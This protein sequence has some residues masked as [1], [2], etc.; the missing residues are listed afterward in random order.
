M[1]TRA[2]QRTITYVK[3]GVNTPRGWL[4]VLLSGTA[5]CL[6]LPTCGGQQRA[7][8]NP[9]RFILDHGAVVCG[10]LQNKRIALIFTGGDF[11]EGTVP[12]LDTLEKQK[13]KAGVFVTGAYLSDAQRWQ[14]IERA[15]KEGHYVGP[16]SDRHPLYCPWEDREKSLIGKA[17]FQADLEKNISDLKKLGALADGPIYF[18]PPYE[19]FNSDQAKWV[20]EMGVK[21]F[22]FSPGSGSNRD[23]VPESHA[24][25]VSS[26]EILRDIL[27]YEKRDPHGLN[28]YILLLHLGADRKDKTF[29]LLEPLIV[30]LRERGYEF[31]R[32]DRMLE[33]NGG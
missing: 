27:T 9:T 29:R 2:R 30:E 17:E 32:I 22:N 21:L 16:H 3:S 4:L 25:F 11:G 1:R 24:K 5:L 19:W 18:I 31:V 12:I 28:G 23:Y 6:L 10:D 8:G 33:R 26:E 7:A 13:I 15:V 14:F 20:A